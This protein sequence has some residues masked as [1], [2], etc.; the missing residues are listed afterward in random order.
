[1]NL[2]RTGLAAVVGVASGVAEP[3]TLQPLTLGTTHIS[4][5][6][7]VEAVALVGGAV[8][9]FMMPFTLPSV[10][11]GLVDGSIALLASRGTK[12]GLA[13]MRPVAA[14]QFGAQQFGAQLV[15]PWAAAPS[16]VAA[17]NGG[18]RAQIGAIHGVPKYSN[19]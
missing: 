1:M 4:Y 14:A 6:T 15:S 17:M 10:A 18:M 3:P 13:Q 7:V 8:M 9:Q 2:V 5:G 16:Q 19:T 12:Y 11:D